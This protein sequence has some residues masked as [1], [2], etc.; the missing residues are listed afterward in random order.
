MRLRP[1]LH[2]PLVLSASLVSLPL[3]SPL[4]AQEPRAGSRTLCRTSSEGVPKELVP[5]M[6]AG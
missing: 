1:R 2:F 3:A 4:A 5:D 6:L